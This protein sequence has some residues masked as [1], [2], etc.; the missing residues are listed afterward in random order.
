MTWEGTAFDDGEKIRRRVVFTV[1]DMTKTID[2]VTTVV[3]LD[4]D[5]ND[6]ELG[7][8]EI[9]FFAQD[10][11]GNVWLFGEY[12]EEYEDG[13]GSAKTPAWIHGF[14]GARAGLAM[15]DLRSPWGRRRLRAG[16]GP[17]DRVERRVVGLRDWARTPVRRSTATATCWSCGSRPLYLP[18]ASQLKYYA[19]DVGT[20]RI[21]WTGPNEEEQEEMVLVGHSGRLTAE[22]MDVA[23]TDG[24]RTGS[25][26]VRTQ[27]C[28]RQ[29]GADGTST[30]I[31]HLRMELDPA[32][33]VSL[34][35]CGDHEVH[36][37][38]APRL[39]D[40]GSAR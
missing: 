26:R 18:G 36:A 40:D 10:D 32:E 20:I 33:L 21:G 25:A 9:M 4:L 28:L 24:D 16:L 34:G 39:L 27:R 5:Y 7:E 17:E 19:P 23:P 11:G 6:D 13:E 30:H 29:Y 2:G 31:A 1:S 12:P 35:V 15:K 38:F 37:V 14:E 22:E 8:Q 3:G